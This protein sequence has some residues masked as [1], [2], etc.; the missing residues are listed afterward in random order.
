M[1]IS[2]SFSPFR[3]YLEQSMFVQMVIQLPI[4]FICGALISETK[5]VKHFFSFINPI[6]IYGLTSF[7]VAQMILVYWMLPIS[8]D[9]AVVIPWVDGLK[10]ISM[11]IAGVCVGQALQK[12]P[13]AIQLFFI[14]YFTAMMIWL[15]LYFAT[16]EVRLCNVYSLSSQ[17]MTGYGLVV[18]S[19]TLLAWWSW[20]VIKDRTLF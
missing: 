8:I 15:G 17:H 6:N 3:I 9:R 19:G 12:A 16:T 13:L 10:I 14:G 7:M 5:S 20:R 18:I 1:A 11:I 4:L 2:L